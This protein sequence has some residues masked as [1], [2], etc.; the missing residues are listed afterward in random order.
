[1]ALFN[2]ICC[3]VLGDGVVDRLAGQGIYRFRGERFTSGA[4]IRSHH[5]EIDADSEAEAVRRAREAIE[6][7]GGDAGSVTA[8]TA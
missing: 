5:L 8:A 2:V 1:M 4:S 3:S 6:T 7:A